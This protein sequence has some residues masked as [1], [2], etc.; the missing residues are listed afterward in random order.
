[1]QNTAYLLSVL[2]WERKS[3]RWR[4]F[5]REGRGGGA[6]LNRDWWHNQKCQLCAQVQSCDKMF[7]FPNFFL[8]NLLRSLMAPSTYSQLLGDRKQWRTRL[9][10]DGRLEFQSCSSNFYK[11]IKKSHWDLKLTC[12]PAQRRRELR[13]AVQVQ[14]ADLPWWGGSLDSAGDLSGSAPLSGV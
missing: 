1:M 9:I 10:R 3:I 11:K 2:K 12:C 6:E 14:R 5:L 13:G 4:D 7:L 8:P